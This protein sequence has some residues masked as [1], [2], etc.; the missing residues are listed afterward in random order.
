MKVVRFPQSISTPSASVDK[1]ASKRS[2]RDQ[3]I[4]IAL[5]SGIGLLVSLIAVLLG[6][7]G[8]WS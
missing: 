5:F 6:V 4:S 2:D 3:F 1:A 8:I 7:A